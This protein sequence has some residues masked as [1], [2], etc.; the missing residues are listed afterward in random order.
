MH[1]TRS[2]WLN[3]ELRDSYGKWLSDLGARVG[4]WDWWVTLTFRDRELEGFAKGWTKIGRHYADK[5]FRSWVQGIPNNYHYHP[6]W[7][8]TGL[9]WVRGTETT[10][11]REIPHFHALISGC[12]NQVRQD[13]WA[14]WFKSQG[15]AR[16]EP[17]DRELGAGYYLCKYAVK[18]LGEIEFSPNFPQ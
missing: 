4:G 13:A 5:S 1:Q 14:T 11:T 7:R 6:A 3:H 15:I 18:S 12:K 16:I 2:Y 10:R 17:Y 9:A 8:P